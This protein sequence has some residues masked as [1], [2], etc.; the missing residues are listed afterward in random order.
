MKIESVSIAHVNLSQA[1]KSW[2][3]SLGNIAETLTTVIRL[4]TDSGVVGYGAAPIGAQLISGESH[5]SA[6]VFLRAARG[7][8]L[9]ADPLAH[10]AVMSRVSGLM[11]GNARA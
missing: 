6:E 5:A 10:T 7:I 8:L 3:I 1:D 11:A 4:E 2:R 9:G